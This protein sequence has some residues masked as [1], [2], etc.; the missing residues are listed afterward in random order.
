MQLQPI[1]IAIACFLGRMPGATYASVA[2]AL[3]V[4]VSTAHKGADRLVRS[5]LVQELGRRVNRRALLEFIEHGVRYAF[6]TV[7]GERR[8]RGVPTAHAGPDLA[9]QIV[10]DEPLVWPDDSSSVVGKTIEPLYEKA[11]ALR[12]R[13]PDVYAM[14]ADIDAVRVGRVRERQLGMQALRQRLYGAEMAA[15]GA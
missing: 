2:D 14:L 5:G 10:S 15:A 13:C 11:P 6:P 7:I 8:R 1:D 12:D 9:A 3:G 4:S